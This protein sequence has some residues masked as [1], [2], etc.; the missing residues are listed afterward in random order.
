MRYISCKTVS[1]YHPLH[2]WGRGARQPPVVGKRS[3][4]AGLS[5]FVY[6]FASELLTRAYI[7]MWTA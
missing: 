4:C 5:D 6:G 1:L 7:V 2:M 3:V